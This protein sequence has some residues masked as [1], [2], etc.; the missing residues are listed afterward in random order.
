VSTRISCRRRDAVEGVNGALKGAFVNI[1]QNFFKVFGLIKIKLLLAFTLA[2][3]NLE[4]IRSFR[5]RKAVEAEKAK[6]PRPRR[7][8]LKDSWRDVVAIP[9]ATGPDPPPA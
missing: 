7:K 8:R 5:A 1:G 9:P 6:K 3:Y 4:T 2:A